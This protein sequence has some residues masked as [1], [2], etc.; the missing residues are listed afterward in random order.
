M[1]PT[2]TDLTTGE[3]LCVAR[4][5]KN[6]TQARFAKR[7]RVSLTTY[8]QIEAGKIP[9]RVRA[10]AIYRLQPHEACRIARKRAGLTLDKLSRRLKLSKWWLCLIEQGKAP[11][12]T[13]L[14][15]WSK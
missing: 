3:R 2:T 8:R 14:E 13:L 15:F 12:R 9:A 4:R 5:R 1:L 10:P 7:L 11:T 6:R